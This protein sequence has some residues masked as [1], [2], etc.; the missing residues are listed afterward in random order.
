MYAVYLY[1]SFCV[2]KQ[3]KVSCQR[4]NETD[5]CLQLS[6]NDRFI[7]R[8]LIYSKYGQQSNNTTR[9]QHHMATTKRSKEE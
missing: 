8:R 1:T 3:E 6:P 5:V 4:H 2:R 7:C 9:Q